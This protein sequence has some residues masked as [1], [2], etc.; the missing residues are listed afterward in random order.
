M[1]L[2]LTWYFTLYNLIRLGLNKDKW[3]ISH[4]IMCHSSLSHLTRPGFDKDIHKIFD[5]I[6]QDSCRILFSVQQDYITKIVVTTLTANQ[7]TDHDL[8]FNNCN[9]KEIMLQ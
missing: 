5:L 7:V 1:G 4:I 8:S 9:N 6:V 3:R 2:S